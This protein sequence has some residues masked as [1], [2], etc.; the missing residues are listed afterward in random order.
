VCVYCR[1]SHDKR[2]KELSQQVTDLT[3]QLDLATQQ[4]SELQGQTKVIEDSRDAVKRDLA[5]A[6]DNIRRGMHCWSLQTS[7]LSTPVIHSYN[8]YS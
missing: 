8:L 6:S 5:E 1:V 7:L 4:I 3:Q 2:V